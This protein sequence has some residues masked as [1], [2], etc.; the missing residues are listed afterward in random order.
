MNWSSRRRFTPVS[1]G[2]VM[3][4]EIATRH[5]LQLPQKVGRQTASGQSV[6]QC[7]QFMSCDPFQKR[8]P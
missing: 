1:D 3:M 2:E 6:A 8:W 4:S 7:L 5:S